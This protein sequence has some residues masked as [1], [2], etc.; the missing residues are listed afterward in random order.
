[1]Q[2]GSAYRVSLF[3]TLDLG[4]AR[5]NDSRSFVAGDKRKRRPARPVTVSGMDVGVTDAGRDDLNEHFARAGRG[6]WHF[7][8]RQRLAEC[9][10]HPR[11]HRPCHACVSYS[12]AG[13]STHSRNME[14]KNSGQVHA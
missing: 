4:T 7:L 10:H 14:R 5:R 2:P 8:D 1:M 6:N 9:V 3:Q 12:F 13:E 11:F